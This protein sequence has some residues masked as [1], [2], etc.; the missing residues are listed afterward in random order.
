MTVVVEMK[1]VTYRYDTRISDDIVSNLSMKIHQGEWVAIIGK[2]GS[3][4]STLAKLMAGLISPHA[5]HIYIHDIELNEETKWKIRGL[6]GMVFQN[7]DN[8]F[9]GTSVEDDVAFA[10]ENSN[11]SFKEMKKRVEHSLKIVGLEKYKKVD[12]SHLS[13][14]Q[15]QRV[16]I[17]GCLAL[18]PQLLILDEA[19][20]MLDPTNRK[21]LL[22]TLLTIKKLYNLSII[23]ITH[24]MNE[25]ALADRMIVMEKGKLITDGI[26]AHVFMNDHSLEPPFYEKLRRSFK[27]RKRS[28]PDVYMTEKEMD[29]WLCK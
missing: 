14:G 10:L 7:P 11:M 8:Q 2:N 16:A 9:I 24:D 5:G 28:I 15:K 20:S 19:L 18:Q 22:K 25:A 29:E 1:N 17:A 12:P 13:G 6:V 23:S 21:C 26:P 3:G 4:K 27:Q